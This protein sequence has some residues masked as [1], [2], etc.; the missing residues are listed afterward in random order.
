[1]ICRKYITTGAN[2][3][4]LLFFI[5]HVTCAQ[6]WSRLGDNIGAVSK[7]A[8]QGLTLRQGK[9]PRMSDFVSD[10]PHFHW[11]ILHVR[12]ETSLLC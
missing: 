10:R 12:F 8:G 7:T 11:Q 5:P 1:M 2:L 3:R 4:A 6:L 9:L